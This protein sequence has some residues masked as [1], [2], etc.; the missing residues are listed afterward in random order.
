MNPSAKTQQRNQ[1]FRIR[2]VGIRALALI[3]F[4]CLALCLTSCWTPLGKGWKARAGYREAAPVISALE[5]FHAD[6]GDFDAMVRPAWFC[7]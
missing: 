3:F 4:G 5:R 2:H 6:R 7:R 1:E